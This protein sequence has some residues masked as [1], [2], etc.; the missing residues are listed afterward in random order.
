MQNKF[1][2]FKLSTFNFVLISVSV[3]FSCQVSAHHES[4]LTH[5]EQ[6]MVK[7]ATSFEKSLNSQTRI[8]YISSLFLNTPYQANRLIG[9]PQIDETLVIDFRALDCF[10]Y[11]DYVESLRRASSRQEFELLL[12]EVRYQNGDIDFLSRNHFF[13]DW[14]NN[15]RDIVDVTSIVTDNSVSVDKTLNLK[16]DGHAFIE[17]LPAREAQIRYIPQSN[18]SQSVLEQLKTGDYIGIYTPIEGLDVTHVGIFIRNN[19]GMFLRHASSKSS[20]LKVIDSPFMAYVKNTPGIIV[21]RI[22]KPQSN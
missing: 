17:T 16:S 4:A 10:T 21:Y 5:Y 6:L 18:V 8:E 7:K 11:I 9:S 2:L 15:N 1:S 22:D 20:V 14:K 13:V 3:W 19:E 12:P